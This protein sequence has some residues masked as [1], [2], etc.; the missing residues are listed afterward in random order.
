MIEWIFETMMFLFL[1]IVSV[2]WLVL[3][4]YYLSLSGELDPQ[5]YELLWFTIGQNLQP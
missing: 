5:G 1:I 2:C 4:I 3:T